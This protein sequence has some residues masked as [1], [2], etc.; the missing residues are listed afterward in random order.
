MNIRDSYRKTFNKYYDLRINDDEIL[1][2]IDQKC[3]S[4]RK[5]LRYRWAAIAAAL[6]ILMIGTTYVG[7]S[8]GWFQ[9]SG[10]FRTNV[11][12]P[13]SADLMEA[14]IV[15]ELN[16]DGEHD[17]F[18]LKLIA[19]TGDVETHKV[20]FEMIPKES[21]FEMI[22]RETLDDYE[23]EIV[24]QTVSPEVEDRIW[25]YGTRE[26]LSTRV[27]SDDGRD[28]YY[29]SYELPPHWV[30]ETNEDVVMRISKIKLYNKNKS[31]DM[32]L[33]I[34]QKV[35]ESQLAGVI[36]CDLMYR[37]TPDRSIL[38]EPVITPVNQTITKVVFDDFGIP[39]EYK[40]REFY[41]GE[42]TAPTKTRELRIDNITFSNYKA[43]INATIMDRDIVDF[44]ASNTWRQ[45]VVPVFVT[46]HFWNGSDDCNSYEMVLV[47]NT[48]RLR[49]FA[50]GIEMPLLEESLN[51]IFS[52]GEDGYYKCM[53]RYEGFDYENAQN[54]E[55][56]FGDKVFVIK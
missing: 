16:I 51:Y 4:P 33:K 26:A 34:G 17:D 22:P 35:N 29:F 50:D 3:N 43:E 53:C 5:R 38:Q 40:G 21:L 24:G 44:Q 48:E 36:S 39:Y 27:T 18:T 6:V 8:V 55:L 49:L 56:R 11:N 30:K 1:R 25:M 12:D 15:Q 41:K 23:I 14:G 20:L 52:K 7:A 32:P 42:I 28:V 19:F 45:C 31:P 2:Q 47:D 9:L 13:V 46:K 10:I 54:V 37:F